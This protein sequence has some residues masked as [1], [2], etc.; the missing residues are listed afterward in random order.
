MM[1]D[2]DYECSGCGSEERW[3]LH[4]IRHRGTIRRVCTSC[5][6]K[7]HPGLFCPHCFEFYE[8]SLDTLHGRVMCLKCSSVS[9]LACAGSENACQYVC[10]SCLNPSM[11]FFDVSASTMKSKGTNGE[12]VPAGGHGVI[13]QK[14]AKVLLAAARIAAS[15]MSKAAAAARVEA[16]RRVKEAVSTRKKAKEALAFLMANEKEKQRSKVARA[17]V[18][19]MEQ[20]KK[21]KGNSAVTGNMVQGLPK[22]V[23]SI[24]DKDKHEGPS[25][26]VVTRQVEN[27]LAVNENDNSSNS[28]NL[29]NHVV[30]RE[31]ESSRVYSVSM[32][33]EQLQYH[34]N[35]AM[36]E[37]C[38]TSERILNSDSGS[39]RPQSNQ[40]DK[41]WNYGPGN[42]SLLS[43][44]RKGMPWLPDE[45]VKL[46]SYTY[47]QI[48]H[49]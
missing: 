34:N 4:N 17:S 5:V 23:V 39:Q 3:L 18:L 31:N 44:R 29:H 37:D 9:H 14:L 21:A 1:R 47:L 48:L 26:P 2:P 38:G 8:G 27:P 19:V 13:D 43:S 33:P 20:N 12:P 32:A 16:E 49:Q 11:S 15:S 30:K 45:E 36:E 25:A 10:P 6:L 22:N 41:R 7:L 35:H 28:L 42:D 40:G 24:D 46:L